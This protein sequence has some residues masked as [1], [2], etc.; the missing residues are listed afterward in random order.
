MEN[1]FFSTVLMFAFSFFSPL[2][3][4]SLNSPPPEH[5]PPELYDEFTFNGAIPV[6]YSY[7]NSSYS[8][9]HPVVY[10]LEQLQDYMERA[11]EKQ[12]MYYGATDKYL[13]SALEK[14]IACIADKDV[15][16]L[17]STIPWYESILLSYGAHPTTIEY[18][19]IVTT[20]PRLT[21]VT[22]DEFDENPRLFDAVLSI[23]SFE[24][25]GLGRY[26]DPIR[27]NGDLEAME[28]TKKMLKDGGLL[29]L[30]V[31]VGQDCIVWNL[32]RVYGPLRLKALL[33]GWRIVEY[34]GFTSENFYK[35][36]SSGGHQP[37][38]VL[39]PI[40]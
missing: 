28:K 30:A 13:Y 29:F 11:R 33:K 27:P 17:G 2:L 40:K 24:H 39:T 35:D 6:V 23:S 15:A 3:V 16:I 9:D 37:V 34:F 21:V 14:Y 26:G 12:T 31:P 7:A 22:V 5:I 25:D 4:F 19:K 38:F 1:R 36:G 10:S 32:H 20:D 18:N 8:S